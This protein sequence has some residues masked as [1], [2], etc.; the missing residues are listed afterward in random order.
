MELAAYRQ[1]PSNIQEE[2][3]AERKKDEL[4]GAR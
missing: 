1:T 4:A 3:I 2:I